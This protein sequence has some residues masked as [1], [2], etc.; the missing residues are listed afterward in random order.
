MTDLILSMVRCP[1]AVVPATRRAT[2]GEITV[3]RGEDCGWVLDDPNRHLSKHHCTIAFR[4]GRWMR[5]DHSTNGTFLDR[6]SEPVGRGATVPLRDG[7]RL[8]LGEYEI[9]VRLEERAAAGFAGPTANPFDDDP[10]APPPPARAPFANDPCSRDPFAVEPP[11]RP[12]V[13]DPFA[14]LGGGAPAP[15]G[16]LPDDFDPLSDIQGG[17]RLSDPSWTGGGSRPDHS[18][19]ASD[20]FVPPPVATSAIPDDWDL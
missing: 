18:S 1:D 11:A 20:A 13:T 3:G 2:G 6:S 14:G 16:G 19:A 12:V 10:F 4:A 15:G 7:S 9:E 8:G 5:T 17:D